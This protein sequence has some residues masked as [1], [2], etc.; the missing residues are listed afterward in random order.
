MAKPYKDKSNDSYYVKYWKNGKS[1]TKRG[2]KTLQEAKLFISRLQTREVDTCYI[3]FKDMVNEYWE[4]YKNTVEYSTLTRTRLFFDRYIVPNFPNKCMN[5]I[6]PKDCLD[7]QS[8]IG[9]LNKAS[10]YKND[11]MS[12]FKGVFKY[13]QKY[14]QLLSDPTVSLERFKKTTQEK[15]NIKAK[16][17]RIWSPEEFELFLAKVERYMYKLLFKLLFLTGMRKGEVLALTWM[18]LLDHK[19]VISKSLSRKAKEGTYEI[20]EPKTLS[21]IRDVLLSD[22][23][24]NELLEFKKA[25]MKI[26]GFSNKWFIFG[27]TTP[28]AENTLT[29]VKD[30]AVIASG[31]K[32]ISIHDI[33][34]SFASMLIGNGIDIVAVSKMLGHSD[35]S[36]TLKIYTHLLQKNDDKLVNELEKIGKNICSNELNSQKKEGGTEILYRNKPSQNILKNNQAK[37]KAL[38]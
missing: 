22:S 11:I 7:F 29:R 20:K 27:R 33:R 32:M 13:A 30:R 24:Y 16:E 19:L 34:H 1:A 26:P 25:E 31:V 28:I 5:S 2:F 35:V 3:H 12:A 4:Y 17:L 37:R 15:M 36:M 38:M 8:R 18:D 10:G 14:H 6:T 9:E 23:L 21:S